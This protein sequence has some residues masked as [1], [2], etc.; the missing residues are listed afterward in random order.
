MSNKYFF[1]IESND[2]NDAIKKINDWQSKHWNEFEIIN[3]ST[4]T[5]GNNYILT[6]MYKVKEYL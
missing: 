6:I 4:T 5:R 3:L 2:I 1:A